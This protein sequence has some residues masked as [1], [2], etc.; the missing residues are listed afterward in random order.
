ENRLA[1]DPVVGKQAAFHL[2]PPP[3]AATIAGV[4]ISIAGYSAGDLLPAIE[5][6]YGVRLLGDAYMR[7]NLARTLPPTGD[8]VPLYKV[9]DGLAGKSR[10]WELDGGT[11]RL[12]CRTWAHDRRAE[13]P[14]RFTRTWSATRDRKGSLSLDDM[15]QIALSLRDEQV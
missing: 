10:T 2:P 4:P 8:S 7:Q 6:A 12:R 9:L 14:E 3:K 11:V 13:V 15:A 1:A 5:K